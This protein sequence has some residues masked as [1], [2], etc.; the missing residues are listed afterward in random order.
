MLKET[1]ALNKNIVKNIVQAQIAAHKARMKVRAVRWDTSIVIFL[2]SILAL[3]V[4]LRS[5]GVATEVVALVAVAGLGFSLLMARRQ[6][7]EIEKTYLEEELS[8]QAQEIERSLRT[9][10]H[11][12]S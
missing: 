7:C 12:L 5:E 1:E 11:S 4:I 10:N 3:V 6:V 2:F 8:K 9:R